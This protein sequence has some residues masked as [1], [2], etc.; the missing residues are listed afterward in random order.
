LGSKRTDDFNINNSKLRKMRIY[1]YL[2]HFPPHGKPLIGGTSKSVHG[3]A[4]GMSA[5]GADVTIL[6]EGKSNN[7]Y[8]TPLNYKIECFA[9]QS[10]YQT[11]SI[12]SDLQKYITEQINKSDLVILNG[13]FHLSV[14]SMSRLL[15]KHSIPYVVMPHG[16]YALPMFNKSPYFKWPYWYLFERPMLMNAKALQFLDVR[17]SQ[18]LGNLGV[19]KPSIEAPNGFFQPEVPPI[20]TLNWNQTN[21]PKLFFFGRIDIK[22]KGLDLLLKSFSEIS[23]ITDAL[24]TIQGSGS[25]DKKTLQEANRKLILV[26]RVLF[27]EPD[28]ETI[29]SAIMSE[30]DIVCLPSR[31]EGFGLS[32]HHIKASG[33]GVVVAPEVSSIKA[34]ILELL[35]RRSDWQEMGLRGRQYA[36]EHLHWNN[37]AASVLEQYRQLMK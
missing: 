31:S 29:P 17:Q 9:N 10:G 11:F 35:E 13:I 1:L 7:S 19:D 6:C 24:L 32:A 4:A 2:K 33:C 27:L 14:Y 23:S 36:L 28:Y 26:N 34:G 15:K 25:K 37:I 30:Y 21:P 5:C 8:Q 18:W 22:I 12:A 3:L 16:V 20:S